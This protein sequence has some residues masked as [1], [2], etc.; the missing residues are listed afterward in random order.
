M[1]YACVAGLIAASPP[2]CAVMAMPHRT[3]CSIAWREAEPRG[4]SFLIALTPRLRTGLL[5]DAHLVGLDPGTPLLI[6]GLLHGA[7]A[8]IEPLEIIEPSE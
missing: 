4:E 1:P 2:G 8:T 5:P 3:A 7:L 6:R